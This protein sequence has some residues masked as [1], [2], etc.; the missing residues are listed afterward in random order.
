MRVVNC[1]VIAASIATLATGCG[2][3]STKRNMATGRHPELL[4]VE[5]APVTRGSI[6]ATLELV[7]NLLPSRRSI[8][9]AEVDGLIQAMPK[10]RTNQVVVE[11]AGGREVLSLG[12]GSIVRKGEVLITLDGTDFERG[13]KVAEANLDKTKRELEDL[14]AW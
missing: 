9:V 13:L 4:Q 1:F 12:I 8:I 10:P 11:Y 3:A 7:G 5:V 6:S 14:L 2:D